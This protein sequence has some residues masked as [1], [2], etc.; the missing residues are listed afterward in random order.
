[1]ADFYASIAGS[2]ATWLKNGAKVICSSVCLVITHPN[3]LSSLA[4]EELR[5]LA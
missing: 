2:D 3:T 4:R 1:M 5:E